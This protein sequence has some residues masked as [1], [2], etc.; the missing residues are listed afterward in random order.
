MAHSQNFYFPHQFGG[1][2]TPEQAYEAHIKANGK[3][4]VNTLEFYQKAAKKTDAECFNCGRPI[5]RIVDCGMCFSCV[6][7]ESDASDDFELEPA[8]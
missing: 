4:A 6:T 5:W 7:G 3:N 2:Q 8:L 1:Y